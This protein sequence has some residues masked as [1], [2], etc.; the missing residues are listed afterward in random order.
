MGLNALTKN[1][2][3]SIFSS[4][5]LLQMLLKVVSRLASFRGD[6]SQAVLD[7]I[8]V[9]IQISERGQNDCEQE[10][11]AQSFWELELAKQWA[12]L[13]DNSQEANTNLYL[14]REFY[15]SQEQADNDADMK[16]L[17]D[18]GMQELMKRASTSV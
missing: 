5:F 2:S 11:K 6:R 1:A 4:E 14:P 3:D 13:I 7:L 18:L 9:L 8:Q 16:V 15:Q 17:A 12:G 10:G